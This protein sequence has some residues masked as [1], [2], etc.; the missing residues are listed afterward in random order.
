M[1]DVT[2]VKGIKSQQATARNVSQ[3]FL[4][5]SVVRCKQLL[6]WPQVIILCHNLCHHSER[7]SVPNPSSP[8][9][10]SRDIAQWNANPNSWAIPAHSAMQ[11]FP[12][13]ALSPWWLQPYCYSFPRPYRFLSLFYV[14]LAPLCSSLFI[15]LF[16]DRVAMLLHCAYDMWRMEVCEALFCS[17]EISHFAVLEEVLVLELTRDLAL[18]GCMDL[19]LFECGDG[20]LVLFRRDEVLCVDEME[21]SS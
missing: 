7:V 14:S 21:K 11:V 5:H 20:L 16:D 10:N 12:S 1:H 6:E 4:L 8:F 3:L 17:L 9:R 15:H 19:W 18:Y 13:S 2:W